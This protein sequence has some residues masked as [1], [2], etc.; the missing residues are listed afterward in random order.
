MVTV[1]FGRCNGTCNGTVVIYNYD[2]S[3]CSAPL[4]SAQ[5][6]LIYVNAQAYL[7]NP[8]ARE[9]VARICMN[10]SE[11]VALIAGHK[12]GYS[13]NGPN[14]SDVCTGG[15]EGQW[16]KSAFEKDNEYFTQLYNTNE[17]EMEQLDTIWRG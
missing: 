16:T 11:A 15:T 3:N 4:K 6:G 7:G 9:A 17:N 13:S 5:V 14:S 12:E 2:R 10:D 8:D 1:Q